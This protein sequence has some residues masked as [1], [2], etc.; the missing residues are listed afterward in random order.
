MKQYKYVY[1]MC[2]STN[3]ERICALSKAVPRGRYFI[4]DDY[5]RN[6]MNL[7]EKHWGHHSNL[8]RN[9]K[10]TV[11]TN[12][13]LPKVR[14]RGF[15]MA[16]RDNTE[17]RNIIRKFD[18]S[19]S[20]MIYSMWDGYRTKVGSTIPDFLNLVPHWETL[21]TSGHAS[22]SDIKKM[23][24]ITN[25]DVVI[26]MHSENPYMLQSICPDTPILI[27]NDGEVITL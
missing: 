6:L 4:C 14:D 13:I 23:I 9:L 1:V 25:P 10:K 3:L 27:P 11:L 22:H 16:V 12:S 20:I 7:I 2:A 15:L 18:P 26:P 19:Q 21:H 17:F 5:Q 24:K 8:Y